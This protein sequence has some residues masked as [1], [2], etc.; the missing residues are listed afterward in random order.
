MIGPILKKLFQFGKDPTLHLLL[1]KVIV[2]ICRLKCCWRFA[3]PKI[4]RKEKLIN[5][6]SQALLLEMKYLRPWL[7]L[8]ISADSVAIHSMSHIIMWNVYLRTWEKR[9]IYSFWRKLCCFQ[10]HPCLTTSGV[11]ACCTRTYKNT[12]GSHNELQVKHT[13]YQGCQLPWFGHESHNG[14]KQL[15]SCEDFYVFIKRIHW[16]LL[17]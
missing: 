9:C 7:L 10:W 16:K 3:F 4:Y 15:L 1:R 17:Y 6:V 12:S 11:W 2:K 5:F 8:F 14:F 13:V